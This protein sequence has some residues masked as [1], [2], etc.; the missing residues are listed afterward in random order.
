MSRIRIYTQQGCSSSEQARFFLEEKGIPYDEVDIDEDPALRAEMMELS[1]GA[2]D[3]PQVFIDG[4]HIGGLD[5]LVEE[6]RQGRLAA[7]MA[8]GLES[9]TDAS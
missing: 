5:D 3:T 4:E 8:G 6:D 1:G 7:I 2:K 9:P